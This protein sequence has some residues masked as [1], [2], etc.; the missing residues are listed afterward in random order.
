MKIAYFYLM[1]DLDLWDKERKGEGSKMEISMKRRE[2]R[3][4]EEGREIQTVP[5]I[6]V[7]FR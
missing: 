2:G 3:R 4:E 6:T 1:N 7:P 5:M